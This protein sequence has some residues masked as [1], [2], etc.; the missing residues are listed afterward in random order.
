MV[1]GSIKFAEP[2]QR[3]DNGTYACTLAADIV[4]IDMRNGEVLYKTRQTAS[5]TG[6]SQYLAA[7]A[8]RKKIASQTVRAILYGM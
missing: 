5:E 8:C 2:S 6:T 7:E 3:Q 4:C 1:S